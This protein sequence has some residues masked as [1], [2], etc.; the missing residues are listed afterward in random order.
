[1]LADGNCPIATLYIYLAVY[2]R[3][4]GHGFPARPTRCPLRDAICEALTHFK[5]RAPDGA[6]I[7]GREI[8]EILFARFHFTHVHMSALCANFRSVLSCI[9]QVFACDEKLFHFAG[10]SGYIRIVPLKRD[11]AIWIYDGVCTLASGDHFL[12]YCRQSLSNKDTN[13]SEPVIGVVAQWADIAVA[14]KVKNDYVGPVLAYDSY[15]ATPG[16]EKSCTNKS[17]LFIASVRSDRFE[18][19]TAI[20]RRLCPPCSQAWQY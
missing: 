7:P 10:K 20:L 5:T 12:V 3:I 16:S 14:F 11:I 17:V 8:F 18:D 19:L 4:C 15:Y 9:G 1:M 2:I 13:V 6:K